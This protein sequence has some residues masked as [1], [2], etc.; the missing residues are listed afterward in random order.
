[1][2]ISP[3]PFLQL[4]SL[5]NTECGHGAERRGMDRVAEGVRQSCVEKGLGRIVLNRHD[6]VTIGASS[7]EVEALM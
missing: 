1:M 2:A 7:G 4:S 6:I 3:E 5:A